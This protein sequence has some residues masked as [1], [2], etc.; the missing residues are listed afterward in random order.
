MLAV[1]KRK[2]E[3]YRNQQVYNQARRHSTVINMKKEPTSMITGKEQVLR[4]M[5]GKLGDFI[6]IIYHTGHQM[7]GSMFIIETEGK[8][9]QMGK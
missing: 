5:V 6:Q 4:A 7:P 1:F 9:L 2:P 8:S 3:H